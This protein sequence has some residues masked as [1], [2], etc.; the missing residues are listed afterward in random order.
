MKAVFI[1][2]ALFIIAFYV[3]AML[4]GNVGETEFTVMSSIALV[5]CVNWSLEK[6]YGGM[7]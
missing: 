3:F 7:Q 4:L 5:I 2:Y 1:Y 6:R